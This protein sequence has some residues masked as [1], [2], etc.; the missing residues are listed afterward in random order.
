MHTFWLGALP[1]AQANLWSRSTKA[2][3]SRDSERDVFSLLGLCVLNAQP[4]TWFECSLSNKE[5][6]ESGDWGKDNI[7]SFLYI[8]ILFHSKTVKICSGGQVSVFSGLKRRSRRI[9]SQLL[10]AIQ[11]PPWCE[12]SGA[13]PPQALVSGGGSE[14][15]SICLELFFSPRP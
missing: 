10:F 12:P 13:F 7:L 8:F 3:L 14:E 11:L 5:G 1:F 6:F 9:F 15:P 2:Y 4:L